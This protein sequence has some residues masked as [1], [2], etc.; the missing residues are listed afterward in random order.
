MKWSDKALK[1]SGALNDEDPGVQLQALL[2]FA[3]RNSS[4]E[5]GQV[6]FDL[7]QSK[8][9]KD[10]HWLSNA[11][12]LAASRNAAGFI[13]SFL[14]ANP[15]YEIDIDMEGE[16]EAGSLNPDEIAE[17][18]VGNYLDEVE[19]DLNTAAVELGNTNVINIGTIKN[20]MK[21]DKTSF[22]VQAGEQVELVFSNN[23][24]MQHNL[25][26]LEPGSK[27]KV[28]LAADQLAADPEG[29]EKDYIPDLP[30]ILHSTRIIN[31]QEKG[32]LRFVA[33]EKPGIY[34]FICTFPGH[35]RIM[36]GEMTVIAKAI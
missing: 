16:E 30:E 3:D 11:V 31:P 5:I 34:P 23:D 35:W 15:N 27:E 4:E 22:S 26:I 14:L 2:Y 6:L 20:E 25:L 24:F 33:P 18:F 10:D 7:S 28:G 17:T 9:I 36:Q 32:V 1:D 29:A 21:Y 12:Y 8:A 19:S 13:N